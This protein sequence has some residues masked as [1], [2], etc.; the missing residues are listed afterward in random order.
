MTN[1]LL[2]SMKIG[3]IGAGNMSQTIIKGIIESKLIRPEQ[4]IVSNRTPGKLIKVTEL[5]HVQ[6]REHNEHIIEECDVI[7]LAMKPQDLSAAVEVFANH[8]EPHQTIISLAAGIN[9][10]SLEK[11]MPIGRLVRLMPNTPSVIGRG[12]IGFLTQNQNEIV[13]DLMEDLFSSLGVLLEVD[14]ED[15]FD[16]LMI[17]CSSGTGFVFE[18]MMYWQDWIQ[19]RGF[20]D[21]DSKKMTVETFLGAS[22]LAAQSAGID[23]EELQA[24][25]TSKKGVTA[26]GLNSMR[27]LEIE[28]ALRISFEKAALRSK[29]L[30]LDPRR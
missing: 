15:Q 14:T 18:M 25:V 11:M 27:E 3:F 19:E 1:P 9:L 29:E 20:S 5:F 7:I 8:I 12:V 16:A 17:S 21:E 4:I 23:I 28:R 24:R 6:T 26:A 10:K 22:L 2:K 30:S 13:G